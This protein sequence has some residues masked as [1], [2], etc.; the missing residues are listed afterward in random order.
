MP[1]SALS[2]AAKRAKSSFASDINLNVEIKLMGRTFFIVFLAMTASVGVACTTTTADAP[3]TRTTQGALETVQFTT[4]PLAGEQ[5]RLR[6]ENGSSRAIGANLC[7]ATLEAQQEGE[8]QAAAANITRDCVDEHVVI[9]PGAHREATY[10]F[11][12]L[13]AGTYRFAMSIEIPVGLGF[14]S[15]ASAPF[16]VLGTPE[17][18]EDRI[19]GVEEP[20]DED[21]TQPEEH[22]DATD[23]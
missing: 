19:E 16:D 1:R 3:S 15:I 12:D 8:W 6:L 7:T 14:E 22:L 9:N 17:E 21:E 23:E 18:I 10:T 2:S 4:T 20:A 13:E 11:E 5:V